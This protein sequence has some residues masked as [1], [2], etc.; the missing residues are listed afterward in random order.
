VLDRIAD[1]HRLLII[2]L[3]SVPFV[4]STAVNTIEGLAHKAQRRQVQV[5]L[6]GANHEVRR[7]LQKHRVIPP[8]VHFAATVDEALVTGKQQL[9]PA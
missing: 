3:T 2:D 5:Y 7:E 8:L 1:T 9:Q 6:T 4:D